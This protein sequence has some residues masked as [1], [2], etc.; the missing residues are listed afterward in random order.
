MAALDNGMNNVRLNLDDIKKRVGRVAHSYGIRKVLLFGSYFDGNP[1]GES[2][3]DLLVSYGDGCRGLKRIGFMQD[4]E[5]SLGKNVDVLNIEFLPKF[6]QQSDLSD[7]RRV[8]YI[9]Q[10]Q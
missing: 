6:I 1:T 3:V 7:E 10:E 8:I 4:L 2:D 9:G 5:R